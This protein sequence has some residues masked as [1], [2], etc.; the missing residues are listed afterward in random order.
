MTPPTP[1]STK[2]KTWIFTRRARGTNDEGGEWAP[3]RCLH[4]VEVH[5]RMPSSPAKTEVVARL[6]PGAHRTQS[7]RRLSAKLAVVEQTLQHT[8]AHHHHHCG[9]AHR[10]TSRHVASG[11]TRSRRRC[12]EKAR[13]SGAAAQASSS[14]AGTPS[15]GM[16]TGY[17]PPPPPPRNLPAG[18]APRTAADWACHQSIARTSK[19]SSKAGQTSR[20]P[21]RHDSSLRRRRLRPARPRLSPMAHIWPAWLSSRPPAIA[22]MAP[23]TPQRPRLR[24]EQ[25]CRRPPT[26][27]PAHLPNRSGREESGPCRRRSTRALPGGGH[28]RRPGRRS[29]SRGAGGR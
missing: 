4:G 13:T 12:D 29:R 16:Q 5:P 26:R 25:S 2:V 15:P 27:S 10:S 24:T 11:Q 20:H 8:A 17:A 21:L 9:R 28:R 22:P 14:S 18:E 6:S 1:A 3:Q 19:P 7:R 23:F